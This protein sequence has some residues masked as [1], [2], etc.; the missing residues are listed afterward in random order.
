MIR[1]VL[2]KQ[3]EQGAGDIDWCVIQIKVGGEVKMLKQQTKKQEINMK[4]KRTN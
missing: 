3:G 2:L 1:T 4:T